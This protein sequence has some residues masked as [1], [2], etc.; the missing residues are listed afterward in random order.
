MIVLFVARGQDSVPGLYERMFAALTYT[1]NLVNDLRGNIHPTW[2]SFNQIWSLSI[3]D[4]FYLVVPL[5]I[6]WIP[7][8]SIVPVSLFLTVL[9]MFVLP[10]YAGLGLGVLLAASLD[11]T[12]AEALSPRLSIIVGIAFVAAFGLLFAVGQTNISQASWITY[13]LSGIVVLLANYI[14]L[15]KRLNN[16]L[17][18]LGPMT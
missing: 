8:R 1:Y 17:R 15:P 7:V 18:Y 10:L 3:E 2:G 4:Q 11:W 14:T 13:L 9:F 16:G 6:G 5:L 12:A